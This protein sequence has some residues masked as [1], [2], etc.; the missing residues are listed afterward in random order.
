MA[1]LIDLQ[2]FVAAS[3]TGKVE[4]KIYLDQTAD[5]QPRITGRRKENQCG[6]N[7]RERQ[8]GTE[9]DLGR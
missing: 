5:K 8:R 4:R 2:I 9:Y 1:M 3:I 6:F 7:G